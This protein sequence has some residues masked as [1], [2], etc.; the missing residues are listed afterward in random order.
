MDRSKNGRVDAIE[1][2]HALSHHLGEKLK[3]EDVRVLMEEADLNRDGATFDSAAS[4]PPCRARAGPPL[5]G[6]GLKPQDL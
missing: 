3:P 6:V 4:I 2:A 5:T 1:L